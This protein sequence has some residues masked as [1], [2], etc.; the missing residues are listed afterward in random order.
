MR[1][2]ASPGL[3]PGR[4]RRSPRPTRCDGARG[5]G[6]VSISGRSRDSRPA[7]EWIRVTSSASSR[8]E[9]GRS[10]GR[11]RA[12]IVFPVPGGPASRR[13]WPP[14]AASSSARRA[15]SC[16]RTSARSGPSAR[17]T[18][19]WRRLDGG[20]SVSPRRY[21]TA[22]AR[23]RA[24]TAR[25]RPAQPRP[26]TRPRRADGPS[27]AVRAPSAAAS[28]PVTGRSRPSSASSPIAAWPASRSGGNCREAARIASAIGQVE[29]RA[30]LA[31]VRRCEVD[32]D[33]SAS[34][35]RALPT[36]CRSEPDAWPPGT[37]GRRARRSRT[38]GTAVLEVGLHLDP[39]RLEADERMGDVRASTPPTVRAQTCT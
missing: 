23:W 38:P 15:R 3:G 10:P 37:R 32:G 14:A 27:P 35:T 25:L 28:T 7:T 24:A 34:A 6:G 17:S 33:P 19:V 20:G 12:S 5:T 9:R 18:A 29:S 31:Q 26:P 21:A 13:L 4:R 11:R 36:R 16:P 1:E 30:L 8:V 39:A 2:L 22:S